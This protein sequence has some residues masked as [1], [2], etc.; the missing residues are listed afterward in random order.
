MAPHLIIYH[1]NR[2]SLRKQKDR[3]RNSLAT[4]RHVIFFEKRKN[5]VKEYVICRG[6]KKMT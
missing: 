1:F 3:M 2:L 4:A 5:I 6:Y